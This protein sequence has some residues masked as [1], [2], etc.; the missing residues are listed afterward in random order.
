M[1]D[2]QTER[3]KTQVNCIE[4]FRT[5]HKIIRELLGRVTKIETKIFDGFSL[6]IDQNAENIDKM[7]RKVEKIFAA[8]QR[9]LW[10]ML[11]ALAGIIAILIEARL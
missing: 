10:V 7:D 8:Q 11:S 4:R 3:R 2:T 1:S 9:L 5:L 6:K